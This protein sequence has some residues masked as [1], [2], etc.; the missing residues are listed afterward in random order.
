MNSPR[1]SN[2]YLSRNG[3]QMGPMTLDELQEVFRGG[4]IEPTDHVWSQELGQWT[5]ASQVLRA[6]PSLGR[7][8][9][10]AQSKPNIATVRVKRVVS[11]P[12]LKSLPINKPLDV[13]IDGKK[14]GELGLDDEGE[15]E[16]APGR[17]RIVTR[18]TGRR[19]P[20]RMIE[21]TMRPGQTE[22]LIHEFHPLWGL[23]FRS[24]SSHPHSVAA[25]GGYLNVACSAALFGALIAIGVGLLTRP[26]VFGTSVPIEI[27]WSDHPGD[28]AF[29]AQLILHLFVA[30]AIGAIIS[31]V[32]ALI[33]TSS[34][35]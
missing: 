16:V 5:L 30:A 7:E 1:G 34:R 28:Q 21:L 29:R 26:S 12:S 23:T 33:Y 13:F 20:T 22:V 18:P 32:L 31:A 4:T 15:F 25:L 27:L 2:W 35:R 19:S 3:Q 14:V 24:S 11:G 6:A 17:H 10:R 8:L 9:A